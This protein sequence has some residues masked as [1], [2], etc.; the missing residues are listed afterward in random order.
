MN[1][2]EAE[3]S[4]VRRLGSPGSRCRPASG[5]KWFWVPGRAKVPETKLS[6]TWLL[7]FCTYSM[8]TGCELHF[9]PGFQVRRGFEV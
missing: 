8:L 7:L 6:A 3:L 2:F 5:V 9:N 1:G 4:L